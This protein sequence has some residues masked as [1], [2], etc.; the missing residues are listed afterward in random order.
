M[1]FPFILLSSNLF[2]Y[3]PSSYGLVNARVCFF[4]YFI[5]LRARHC[6]RIMVAV[7]IFLSLHLSVILWISIHSVELNFHLKLLFPSLFLSFHI[8]VH[9]LYFIYESK[10]NSPSWHFWIVNWKLVWKKNKWSHGRPPFG[11]RT[12]FLNCLLACIFLLFF[13]LLLMLRIGSREK[14]KWC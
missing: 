4:F 1:R 8:D 2:I 6:A 13:L 3:T 11:C 5:H 10:S 12:C 14:K 9:L 7:Y